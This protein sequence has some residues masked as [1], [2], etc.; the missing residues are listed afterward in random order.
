M[1]KK[2]AWAEQVKLMERQRGEDVERKKLELKIQ[3][4]L[5]KEELRKAEDRGMGIYKIGRRGKLI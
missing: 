5:E 1:D 4:L 2:L 3:R